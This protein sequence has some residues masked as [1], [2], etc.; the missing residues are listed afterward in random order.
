MT[1]SNN[2]IS[3][4][5]STQ[6][7]FFVR[8]DH[9]NFVAFLEA[10]YEFLEQENET[11]NQIKTI[12]NNY[13]VDQSIELFIDRFYANFL[14]QIPVEAVVDRTLL[15]KHVKDL[16]RSRGTEKSIRLLMRLLF[17]EE[18]Q[19]FYYP[20]RDVLRASDGK[21]LIQKALKVSDVNIDGI[22]NSSL[23]VLSKF[24]SST[25][26]GNTSNATAVVETAD[27]YFEGSSLVN[28]L[29]ISNQFRNFISGEVIFTTFVENG[30][31]R[32]LTATIFGGVLNT[33]LVTN[34]GTGYSV[35]DTVSIESNTG[36]GGVV[37][38]SSVSSGGIVTVIP[39]N[40]GAGF[41]VNNSLLF[42]G[43]SGFGAAGNV[44]MV[45]ADS[46]Y[47]P[48]SYNIVSSTIALEAN[49]TIG[50]AVYSNLSSSNVNTSISNAV[51]YF[52]YGNT[53]PISLLEV[54][55]TG[56][57]YLSLPTVSVSSNAVIR[58][59]GIL[60][61]MSIVNGGTNYQIGNRIE[62]INVIGGYGTGAAANVTNVAAN[63]AITE[64][65]FVP[66][67]G[68]ITGGTGYDKNFLPIAN[69][70]STTGTNATVQVVAILGEGESLQP[71][72]GT[73]GLVQALTIISRGGGYE[74]PPTINLQS[75][76]DGTAQAVATIITGVYTYPGRYI[77]DDGHL[78][79]YNF[80]QNRDY[81]QDYSYV[82]KIGKSINRYRKALK[83]LI[84]P[85]GMKVFGEYVK[86]DDGPTMNARVTVAEDTIITPNTYSASYNS[87]GYANGSNVFIT[88]T[89][90]VTNVTNVYIEFS[91]GNLSVL[92]PNI[93]SVNV[94]N[95]LAFRIQTANT[96]N[97]T[98]QLYYTS[99]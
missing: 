31:T 26:R 46:L 12:R 76:G 99:V 35:G 25:I 66:V 39:I 13:D 77:N 33:V 74:T 4:L 50:N 2:K 73:A 69:V 62:F 44:K 37:I 10:Y 36:S 60:G 90:S 59:L 94:I 29:K 11:L 58:S 42:T 65:K 47:H 53:G 48:N 9:P 92:T 63:G 57:N 95:S 75:I 28:E 56:N 7:P 67:S 27:L 61:R 24:K 32:S 49:T 16:Y 21:W 18:V 23:T 83:E 80:L 98:G 86:I 40:G 84:H 15:L 20:K 8:N 41:Q 89:R 81:Y 6:L 64:V 79:G 45:S 5:V 34:P 87:L 30:V 70:V 68:Q 72:S 22:P 93:Y 88:T 96:L 82:I 17:N 38:V 19:E 54:S 71:I 85:A 97:G 3:H 51:S 78:S 91:S 1:I 14:K 43:G 55:A 52:V